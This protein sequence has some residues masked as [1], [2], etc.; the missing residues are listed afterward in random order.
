MFEEEEDM[1][2]IFRNISYFMGPIVAFHTP[3]G[4]MAEIFKPLGVSLGAS[5]ESR[6]SPCS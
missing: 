5:L 3:R 2:L 1:N 4:D 6:M